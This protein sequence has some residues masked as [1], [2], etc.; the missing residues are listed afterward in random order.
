MKELITDEQILAL[1]NNQKRDEFLKTWPEWPVLASVPELGLIVRQVVLPGKGQQI[2]SLEYGDR[3]QTIH[4]ESYRHCYFQ[5]RY[6]KSGIS[7][8]NDIGTANAID[9]LKKSRMKIASRR[10][11][12]D[13]Q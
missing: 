8:Y 2:I 1:T 9:T 12:V 10:K 13:K 5:V 7:P 11:E 4:N 6:S 3:G